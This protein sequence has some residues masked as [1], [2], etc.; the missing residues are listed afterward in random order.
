VYHVTHLTF[1]VSVR[2]MFATCRSFSRVLKCGAVTYLDKTGTRDTSAVYLLPL[3]KWIYLNYVLCLFSIVKPTRCTNFSSLLNIML[4]VSDGL[5]VH[6]QESKIV[7][8]AS[9]ICHTGS[10][11]AC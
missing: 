2:L 3:V 4:R 5:S 11:T 9:G 7:H 6:H 10:L 8:T 1:H